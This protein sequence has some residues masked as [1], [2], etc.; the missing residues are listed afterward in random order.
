MDIKNLE[1]FVEIVKS[2]FNLTI[3]S[4]KLMV[5][6]PAL[7]Q[8]IKAF[9]IEENIELFTRYKGRLRGLTPVGETFYKNALIM[10]E[11]Y[12]NMMHELREAAVKL[13]GKIRIGMPPLFLGFTF[14]EVLSTLISDNTDIEFEII[15]AGSV[16]LGKS[17]LSGE[18]DL[19]I[20]I[21]PSGIKKNL[22]SEHLIQSTELVAIMSVNNPLAKG[23]KIHFNDLNDRN[24]AIFDNT[25]ATYHSVME[26]L[27]AEKIKPK[28]IIFSENWDYLLMFVRKSD[29]ITVF[30][31]QIKDVFLLNDV[32]EVRFHDPIPWNV[33]ICRTKK[34]NYS[35][36]EKFVFK[37]IIDYFNV[38]SPKNTVKAT[39][40]ERPD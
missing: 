30:P 25:F 3:A 13:K 12:R 11:N 7:S 21:Q 5:S 40:N 2:D 14:S 4:R 27:E 18:L 10:T 16:N 15:E 20:L 32:A 37:S 6:Q 38:R 33:V 34:K 29:F 1:Y 35:R 26:R 39:A 9:E 17:I 36:I 19:A 24:L 28:K 22:V 23:G 31:S 8:V